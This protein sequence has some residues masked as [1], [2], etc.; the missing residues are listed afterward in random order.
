[1]SNRLL[2][3]YAKYRR[4]ISKPYNIFY[5]G[6]TH[7]DQSASVLTDI[8]NHI[9]TI[10]DTE[11]N[12]HY[13]TLANT[14]LAIDLLH[15]GMLYDREIHTNRI[16]HA[17][18]SLD[19]N[20]IKLGA[21][22]DI[23]NNIDELICFPFTTGMSTTGINITI[24]SEGG[25]KIDYPSGNTPSG[26]E[27][28]TYEGNMFYKSKFSNGTDISLVY[29]DEFKHWDIL[30]NNGIIEHVDWIC[31]SGGK[32]STNELL[33]QTNTHDWDINH[34]TVIENLTREISNNHG[35][36]W[37]VSDISN[38]IVYIQQS[39]TYDLS[40]TFGFSDIY[41]ISSMPTLNH[42]NRP[43]NNVNV[44]WVDMINQYSHKKNY[45]AGAD[46]YTFSATD[47]DITQVPFAEIEF[48]DN[49]FNKK[50]IRIENA[51]LNG[52]LRPLLD[53]ISGYSLSTRYDTKHYPS[54]KSEQRESI[55][56]NK[57]IYDELYY[58]HDWS[59]VQKYDISSDLQEL[60]DF[61]DI[62]DISNDRME[63][64]YGIDI[65]RG[66]FDYKFPYL[67][68][69]CD[70]DSGNVII[71]KLHHEIK[72]FYDNLT[73]MS[74]NDLTFS[75]ASSVISTLNVGYAQPEM[76]AGQYDFDE[77]ELMKCHVEM[78]ESK[79][80]AT[81]KSPF[82]NI[83][84]LGLQ[85][86]PTS[87]LF[88]GNYYG[89][90]DTTN[91]DINTYPDINR[92]ERYLVFKFKEPSTYP[93]APQDISTNYLLFD[94]ITNEY[95]ENVPI[96][97]DPYRMIFGLQ[98][99]YDVSG[100]I[101]INADIAERIYIPIELNPNVNISSS[102][103]NNTN[104]FILDIN[105]N[106]NQFLS[107]HGIAPD[108]GN[109]ENVTERI[110]SH[111]IPVKHSID[112]KSEIFF[113][114]ENKPVKYINGYGISDSLLEIYEYRAGDFN[115]CNR[116][117]PWVTNYELYV[118]NNEYLFHYPLTG[119]VDNKYASQWYVGGE[120]HI[121]E[122][123]FNSL[124]NN[125]LM[126]GNI[127]TKN[128]G[129]QTAYNSSHAKITDLS[130]ALMAPNQGTK[131]YTYIP[132]YYFSESTK[133]VLNPIR[134][135]VDFFG[136]DFKYGLIDKDKTTRISNLTYPSDERQKGISSI[137][138]RFVVVTISP[139]DFSTIY[140]TTQYLLP[141]TATKYDDGITSMLRNSNRQIYTEI[142]ILAE[143]YALDIIVNA[144]HAIQTNNIR[145]Q[146][147][148]RTSI[149]FELP[150]RINDLT[151]GISETDMSFIIIGESSLGNIVNPGY[152]KSCT[153]I[154]TTQYLGG[155]TAFTDA[156]LSDELHYK[157]VYNG[158][159]Y[160]EWY[161]TIRMDII[162]VYDTPQIFN[163]T[164]NIYKNEPI[165]IDLVEKN[166]FLIDDTFSNLEVLDIIGPFNGKKTEN[167]N[168]S[169]FSITY[170]PDY[171]WLGVDYIFFK[172]KT[173]AGNAIKSREGHITFIVTPPPD[174]L[175]PPV[176][177]YEPTDYEIC[178]CRPISYVN[179]TIESGGNNP[180]ITLAEF[181]TMRSINMRH[182][183]K[184]R[185][186]KKTP[187][188]AIINQNMRSSNNLR[189]F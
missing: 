14:D 107:L 8:S 57:Y 121:I 97:G 137:P 179:T 56:N 29:N 95:R 182:Y 86:M 129:S 48:L 103:S 134:S 6:K 80:N 159:D 131:A 25:Y 102:M 71:D 163:R 3:K 96:G 112:R 28:N 141:I 176:I 46:I 170:E 68:Y 88:K 70:K 82:L 144:K 43:I 111:E 15:V 81:A 26:I 105:V 151:Q 122:T 132:S 119:H 128:Q 177:D 187:E 185:Q 161:N 181:Y 39:P 125:E 11:Y 157:I 53:D 140:G 93:D 89:Y 173:L 66:S 74:F 183:R 13:N 79:F 16:K 100:Y 172:V 12:L 87:Y 165:V 139:N 153:F 84:K 164:F 34:I 20:R 162:N 76:N 110:Q 142:A 143:N 58:G 17:N 27:N 40:Y 169:N 113:G 22:C 168:N 92:N 2:N 171:N 124:V 24:T 41:D 155:D 184:T 166:I 101:I 167:F 52:G 109:T 44:Y 78:K 135:R 62:Y 5:N 148:D 116:P 4:P 77:I 94:P 7:Q 188:Q 50:M 174:E 47:M 49:H 138:K 31:A 91:T 10:G 67:F 186:I 160:T 158:Q 117:Y 90:Y 38:G 154:P 45:N 64:Y 18:N 60:T 61:G 189:N 72:N 136:D 114:I 149:N 156:I 146:T 36:D 65:S 19:T 152:S 59:R 1:M 130:M 180:K 63:Q 118:L 73:D 69:K 9:N 99:N 85:D 145:I 33:D 178:N 32:V 51:P 23:T 126:Y 175:P 108:V 83:S 127:V 115:L 55:E 147:T 30:Y 120:K 35:I 106:V 54:L 123:S 42:Q 21:V 150:Y 37:K 98:K 104:V 133:T 75:D